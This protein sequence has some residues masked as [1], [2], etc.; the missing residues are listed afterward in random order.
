MSPTAGLTSGAS[1]RVFSVRC[2]RPPRSAAPRAGIEAPGAAECR[3][4]R[5]RQTARARIR[6][7][8]PRRAEALPTQRR[9]ARRCR[10]SLPPSRARPGR[11]A[12]RLCLRE[13]AHR[14]RPRRSRPHPPLP[15]CHRASSADRIRSVLIY[16]RCPNPHYPTSTSSTEGRIMRRRE[17]GRGVAPAGLLSHSNSRAM[18][19]L[20]PGPLRGPARSWLTTARFKPN[21]CDRL[22]LVGAMHRDEEPERGERIEAGHLR[23]KRGPAPTSLPQTACAF[24]LRPS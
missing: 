10:S 7:T 24:G 1:R 3:A 12:I 9:C 11:G 8:G 2:W 22:V 20:R 15:R 18:S 23:R 17:A 19:G 14:R 5:R 6:T 4:G 16:P 21:A 13:R